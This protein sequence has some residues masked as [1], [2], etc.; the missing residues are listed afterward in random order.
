MRHKNRENL[1]TYLNV[2]L[3]LPSIYVSSIY[4]SIIYL[5]VYLYI[6]LIVS[7]TKS[8]NE[9]EIWIMNSMMP[10]GYISNPSTRW[11]PVHHQLRMCFDQRH[12][13]CCHQVVWPHLVS[14]HRLLLTA[15]TGASMACLLSSPFTVPSM[16]RMSMVCLPS[17][18]AFRGLLTT[19]RRCS[20]ATW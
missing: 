17:L 6:A 3:N 7:Q 8:R 12:T 15:L 18:I 4:L 14:Y 16:T 13:G 19:L 5:S 9:Q 11:S 20:S 10:C 2:H 1:K